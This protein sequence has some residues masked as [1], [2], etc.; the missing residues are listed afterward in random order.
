[1]G[2]EL[3]AL[4]RLLQPSVFFLQLQDTL[5]VHSLCWTRTESDP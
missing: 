1:L 4:K 3:G 2:R 5:I